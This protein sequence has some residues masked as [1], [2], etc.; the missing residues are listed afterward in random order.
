MT[1]KVSPY[2]KIESAPPP[3]RMAR[4]WHCLGPVTNFKDGKLHKVE[5]FGTQIVVWQTSDGALNAIDNYCPHMGAALSEGRLEGDNIA[6]PFHD[7]R[8]SG[9]GKCVEIP[10]ARRVPPG[11]RVK[12]WPLLQRNKLLFV[13]HDP[14]DSLP[15]PDVEIP[16]IAGFDD[17]FSEWRDS[18]HRIKTNTRELIDNLVDIA[19]F[20]YLHGD[21]VAGMCRFF[22]NRFEKHTAW[23]IIEIGERTGSG[24]DPFQPGCDINLIGDS[25][26]ESCYHGPA[27]LVSNVMHRVPTLSGKDDLVDSY[28]F[29]CQVP[30]T[31]E[32]FDLHILTSVRKRPDMTAEENFLRAEERCKWLTFGTLQDVHTWKTKTRI[33]NPILCDGDGPFHQLR[34]WYSQFFVDVADIQPEMVEKFEKI[35]DVSYS[36][37]IWEKQQVERLAQLEAAGELP[38]FKFKM[39]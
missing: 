27:V 39:E 31:P 16:Q 34:R 12:Q 5:A 22:A 13:W 26:S 20:F 25:R 18:V 10:Y 21:R 3:R 6:C 24:Y 36:V 2:Y 32:E 23:Q 7:W 35:T 8:W 17:D 15:T 29:L 33:D 11:A 14:E 30:V 28:I 9:E 19:H 38:I 4:G 1:A 37:P